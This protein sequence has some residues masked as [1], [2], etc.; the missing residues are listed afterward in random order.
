MSP[1]RGSDRT[2]DEKDEGQIEGREGGAHGRPAGIKRPGGPQ[3]ENENSEEPSPK[4]SH[5]GADNQRLATFG[6]LSFHRSPL[7]NAMA[8]RRPSGMRRR[9]RELCFKS[10]PTQEE[11]PSKKEGE[12]VSGQKRC[13]DCCVEKPLG[14]PT[15]GDKMAYE[16]HQ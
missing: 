13:L 16:H 4:I 2:S 6:R 3:Y 9:A 7:P 8:F 15:V 11:R 5:A 1:A 12:K 14:G 10:T